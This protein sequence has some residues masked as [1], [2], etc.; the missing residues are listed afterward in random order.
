MLIEDGFIDS[1]DIP[2]ATFIEEWK[3][4]SKE[5]IQIRDLLNMASG[6]QESYDFSPLP[7]LESKE[8]W[9]SILLHPTLQ[10]KTK[11]EPGT[12]FL[13]VNPNS[14]ILGIIIERATGT[15]I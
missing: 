9:A 12:A 7:Q 3:G 14:Q 11:G 2:A 8:S 4:S 6:I 1:V 10:Q 13:H 15:K 5:K